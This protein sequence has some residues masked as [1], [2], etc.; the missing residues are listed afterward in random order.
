MEHS[1]NEFVEEEDEVTDDEGSE[2]GDSD[3]DDDDDMD[4]QDWWVPCTFR[5]YDLILVPCNLFCFEHF[6][7]EQYFTFS[8]YI[9]LF[10]KY[11]CCKFKALK[12]IKELRPPNFKIKTSMDSL[13]SVLGC[14]NLILQN[15]SP[16]KFFKFKFFP[17]VKD[18]PGEMAILTKAFSKTRYKSWT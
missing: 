6:K 13:C 3:D 2:D 15:F 16:A 9:L 12:H 11:F 5:Y 7:C 4:D 8:P 10:F 17:L 14:S 1:D 18:Y